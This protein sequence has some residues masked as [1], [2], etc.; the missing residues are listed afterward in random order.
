MEHPEARRETGRE[1]RRRGRRSDK[2]EGRKRRTF[3]VDFSI[4][5]EQIKS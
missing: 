4:E 1:E 3:F 5:I 2:E